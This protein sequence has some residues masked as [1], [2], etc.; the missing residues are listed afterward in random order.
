MLGLERLLGSMSAEWNGYLFVC[1]CGLAVAVFV[2]GFKRVRNLLHF[3]AAFFG[4]MY[5]T[6]VIRP[7]L[8][9]TFGHGMSFLDLYLPGTSAMV[10]Q[11]LDKLAIAFVLSVLFFAVG[12]RWLRRPNLSISMVHF[13]DASANPSRLFRKFSLGLIV[14]GYASFLVAQRGFFSESAAEYTRYAGG[15]VFANTT[16]YLEYANYLVVAGVILYF[17]ST[18]RLGRALILALPWLLNQIYVGWQRYMFLNLAIGL[19]VVA[20]F[21]L[22]NAKTN[23]K[24]QVVGAVGLGIAALVLLLIMRGNRMFFQQGISIVDLAQTSTSSP[25]D[26][27]FGDFSGFEG[28]WY[29]VHYADKI[30]PYYGTSIIYRNSVLLIPRLL[31]PDKPLKVEFTWSSLLGGLDSSN[32]WRAGLTNVDDYVWYNTAVKGAIGYAL[33]EWGWPG[34]AINFFITGLFFAFVERRFGRSN[35]SPAWLAAYGATYALVSMQGR[36]DLFEFLIIYFLIFYLPFMVIQKWSSKRSID[37]ATPGLIS[38]NAQ[39]AVTT[40]PSSSGIPR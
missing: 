26:E 13:S 24:R 12:Y 36:N 21:R 29:T 37:Q 10:H 40:R 18:G 20:V 1:T 16:G 19:A 7:Y 39:G 3:A 22:P 27:I 4:L 25:V 33:E 17:A 34:L 15:V 38:S 2:A 32:R 23:V 5:I 8:S 28:T 31:W 35:F 6:F 14:F 30:E 11:D 9:Y